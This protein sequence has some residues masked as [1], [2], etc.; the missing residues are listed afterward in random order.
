[1][2]HKRQLPEQMA[3][4]IYKRAAVKRMEGSYGRN[5]RDGRSAR[6]AEQP[7]ERPVVLQRVVTIPEA[8]PSA[9]WNAFAR[10][11]ERLRRT[12]AKQPQSS[13]VQQRVAPR[14]FAKTG[15][16]ATGGRMKSMQRRVPDPLSRS[17]PVRS[18][19]R[20][21]RRGFLWRVVSIIAGLLVLIIALSF[22]FTG[23]AFRVEQVQVVGTHNAA[24]VQAIQRQ[25]VQGQNIF[26]LNTPAFEAQVENLPLVR[27][28]QVSKQWPNQLT[29]TVQERTPLLLWRTSWETYSIDSDGVLM[30]R[31]SDTPGSDALPTVTAPLTVIAQGNVKSGKVT[32]GEEIQMGM[33]VDANEI[34]FAKDVFER[35]PK[36]IGINAFQL[37][38]DGT[39]YANTMDG[40]GTQGRSKGSYVVESQ[41]GWK[42]YLGDADD[43]NSLENRL[44][45]LKAILDMARE[46]QLSLASIDLR[47][48]LRPVYTLK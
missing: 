25:E 18:G 10:R 3:T 33:R 19:R 7:V 17:V 35:L 21:V 34:Q 38:Y 12:R 30:A 13:S 2:T 29:V 9:A 48:G 11:Q 42:A 8:D 14:T 39:M 23:S 27:S 41:D 44:L 46:Q 37:R 22:I 15:S 16:W 47:Y 1:M 28:A 5:E 32:G 4:H 43:T 31:A 24:L 6:N 20:S 36:I 40:R 45:T 26:L